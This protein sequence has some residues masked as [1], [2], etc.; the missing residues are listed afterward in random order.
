MTE[1][2]GSLCPCSSGA[3]YSAC[4]GPLHHGERQARSAEELMRSRYAAY[5]RGDV[6]YLFRTWHPR[7]RP[8]DV[9][10]DPG[11]TW[12][13]LEVTD[14]LAGGPNDDWGEV[15]FTARFESAAHTGSMHERSR[16][17]RRAGR[18]FYLDGSANESSS[19]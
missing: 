19:T 9:A 6:N 10:V 5:T 2:F 16:F 11:I 12:T 4:C 15:E 3:D 18:W 14:T 13:G 7:T 8:V 17:E 1:L